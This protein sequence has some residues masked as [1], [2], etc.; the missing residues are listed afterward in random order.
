MDAF[1]NVSV[2]SQRIY[3]GL[4]TA[5]AILTTYVQVFLGFVGLLGNSMTLAIITKKQNRRLS[6]CRYMGGL[7]M[8]D[9]L[10][11][12]MLLIKMTFYAGLWKNN[13]NQALVYR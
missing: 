1:S 13:Q 4:E 12:M 10:A 9:S 7:A 5:F 6:T 11:L 2:S 8:A 3:P